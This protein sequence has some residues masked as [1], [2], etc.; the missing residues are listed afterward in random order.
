MILIYCPY[1]LTG[2]P[3]E[4]LARF[5]RMIQ[6]TCAPIEVEVL[7]T[8]AEQGGL[9]SYWK[10]L[11]TGVRLRNTVPRYK[12][13]IL[14]GILNPGSWVLGLACS[15]QGIPFIIVPNG[16]LI[17]TTMQQFRI[18][19]KPLLKW[20]LWLTL[21]RRVLSHASAVV[22]ASELEQQ[23]LVRAG[24]GKCRYV[25]IPNTVWSG[26]A[27]VPISGQRLPTT[28]T[29][30]VLWM[31]RIS[32][33]KG[34]DLLIECWPQVSR[35]CPGALLILAGS[36]YDRHLYAGL[37]RRRA[38]LHLEESI[39][40]RPYLRGN[41]KLEA[42][43]GARCLVLPSHYE[44]F[45]LVV[46][47]ALSLGTPVLVSSGTPWQHLPADAGRMLPRTEDSWV[48]GMVE[49]LSAPTKRRV[50]NDDIHKTLT[51]FSEDE[52]ARQWKAL[53]NTLPP[54]AGSRAPTTC[55]CT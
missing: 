16:D 42:L 36:V 55:D 21:C 9:R 1:G 10:Q 30:Y 49:Y 50:P 26:V 43:A 18:S 3:R 25:V 46:L 33:E 2:G 45:G 37:L 27:E 14:Q 40:F 47:E 4:H 8:Y 11:I 7:E 5:H 31:G 15:R 24:A 32:R 13:A 35:H 44:S 38:R 22:V 29:N 52:V 17:P 20:A 53:I 41:A 48:A 51:P 12:L 19:S 39:I 34:L 28:A 23:R 54:V 6:E